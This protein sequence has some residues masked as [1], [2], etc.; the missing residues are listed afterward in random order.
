MNIV[1]KSRH[2]LG[3]GLLNCYTVVLSVLYVTTNQTY[4]T[5]FFILGL[6][7]I[8]TA[9]FSLTKLACQKELR[10]YYVVGCS[11]R[12]LLL[13][14]IWLDIFSKSMTMLLIQ[15]CTILVFKTNGIQ[16]FFELVVLMVVLMLL[17]LVCFW[18]ILRSAI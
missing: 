6:V 15:S 18:W 3:L 17:K 5:H 8:H 11:K 16:G 2:I 1:K 9:V 10:V 12:K 4:K 14:N 13:K 7:I